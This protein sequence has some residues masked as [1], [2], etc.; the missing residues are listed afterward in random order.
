MAESYLEISRLSKVFSGF[1]AVHDFSLTVRKGEL[2]SLLGPSGC[3]KTTLLRAIAGLDRQTSG[4]IRIAGRD[5]SN[6]PASKRNFGILFQSY[7]LFPNLSAAENIAY[8]LVAR[9]T[10]RAAIEKRVTELLDLVDLESQRNKY[11]AQLSGGQQQRVALARALA[12]SPEL[13]LLDE[14]LSALDAQVRVYLRDEI[15]SL[16]RRLDITTV[17][18][19]H[20]QEEALAISDTVVLMNKG[21]IEQ[22]GTPDALYDHPASRFAA[23]FIGTSSALPATALESGAVRLGAHVLKT[24][25][26]DARSGTPVT[27]CFRPEDVRLTDSIGDTNTI[28]TTVARLSF[29]GASWRAGL[30]L[31]D[32]SDAVVQADFPPATVRSAALAEGASVRISIQQERISVFAGS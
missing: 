8:G 30:A 18:V 24:K 7:A 21:S 26:F 11:P 13:L 10:A 25:P 29:H 32:V 17:L 27:I 28:A 5:V 9:R 14:P 3:G 20:D 22:I 31:A 19:T 2:V 6:M 23:T 12:T 16:Q 15:R 4:E 1:R